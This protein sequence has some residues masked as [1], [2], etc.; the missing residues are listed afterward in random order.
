MYAFINEWIPNPHEHTQSTVYFLYFVILCHTDLVGKLR[1]RGPCCVWLQT[2]ARSLTCYM[3]L[4]E[5]LN[6]SHLEERFNV[7]Y[8][9]EGG[10]EGEGNCLCKCLAQYLARSGLL[11]SLN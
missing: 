10:W 1:F 6:I 3:T 11:F 5:F 4:Y 7:S 8:A 9:P 2:L